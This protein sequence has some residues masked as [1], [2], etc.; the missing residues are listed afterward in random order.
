MATKFCH[1]IPSKEACGHFVKKVHLCAMPSSTVAPLSSPPILGLTGGIAAGKSMV[2]RAL[3]ACGAAV[4]DADAAAKAVYTTNAKL[5]ERMVLRWGKDVGRFN[6]EGIL[7]DIERQRLADIVFRSKDELA[8]LEEQV[9][10]AVASMFDSWQAAKVGRQTPL[11]VVR[12]AAIL[13]ETGMHDRCDLVATVEA[14]EPLRV[15][16]ACERGTRR[17]QAVN[18]EDVLARMA[19]QWS[20]SKR[21]G[22]AEVHLVNDGQVALMPQILTLH[23][24]M[25]SLR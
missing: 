24:H 11:Y 9:H 14:P 10:P 22:L 20:A 7:V 6:H 4:W 12:E 23:R 18:E 16:R 5:R 15:T 19:Q 1:C 21:I 2:A 17:G 8:W 13:F 3:A 25:M